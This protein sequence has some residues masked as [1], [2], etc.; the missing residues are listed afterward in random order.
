MLISSRRINY[1]LL[2][3]LLLSVSCNTS[4]AQQE[5]FIVRANPDTLIELLNVIDFNTSEVEKWYPIE[6]KS[7]EGYDYFIGDVSQY[8]V[9]NGLRGMMVEW[10]NKNAIVQEHLNNYLQYVNMAVVK[11]S[12]FEEVTAFPSFYGSIQM[13]R[14]RY[15]LS[16]M[17]EFARQ[18]KPSVYQSALNNPSFILAWSLL[19]RDQTD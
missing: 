7:T 3:F 9:L 4:V 5:D 11:N 13:L 2:T 14:V 1:L 6:K 18:N 8:S 16:N 15:F 10:G 17:L 19:D 12:S